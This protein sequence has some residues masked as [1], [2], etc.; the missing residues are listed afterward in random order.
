MLL[1]PAIVIIVI[2]IIHACILYITNSTN[3]T[4]VH[5]HIDN[6]IFVSVVAYKDPKWTTNAINILK[7]ASYPN[8]VFIG[9]LEFINNI[10]ESAADEIPHHYRNNIRVKTISC[11]LATYLAKSR[12][13]CIKELFSNERYVLFTRSV[14][15]R[16]NW[17]CIL[18]S[19]MT[20]PSIVITTP[21]CH[22]NRVIFPTIVSVDSNNVTCS[23][24]QLHSTSN[25]AVKSIV[26]SSDFCFCDSSH[27]DKVL[28]DET[29]LGV[30]AYLHHHKLN[31][32]SPGISIGIRDETPKGLRSG[33]VCK[34]N[35][36]IVNEFCKFTDID[37]P[38][39]YISPHARMGLSKEL[40]SEE[41]IIKYGSV[42][43]TNLLLE[44]I[45]SETIKSFK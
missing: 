18:H 37:I 20:S 5:G 28:I 41:C 42:W 29:N 45:K 16:K 17:D 26:W 22:E 30:S 7:N 40:K 43:E 4:S 2:A 13:M 27:I 34:I 8:Q 1:N 21:L 44:Q 9:V 6:S 38:Q 12:K 11:T 23:H 35:Q 24:S 31:I 33:N 3:K 32:F 19:Y 14:V 25:R 15:L 39:K 10:T 36:D